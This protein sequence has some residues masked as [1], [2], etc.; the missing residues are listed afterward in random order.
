[1]TDLDAAFDVL[2]SRSVLLKDE[3]GHVRFRHQLL[4]EYVAA[5]ALLARG[6][7]GELRRLQGIVQDRPLDLYV[8]AVFEQALIYGWHAHPALRRHVSAALDALAAS[9]QVNL[10]SMALVVAAHH[11]DVDAD[12]PGLLARPERRWSGASWR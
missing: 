4:F 10:Q 8:G 7:D 1:M 5:R 3:R 2:L 9:G 11:P 6:R 12:V